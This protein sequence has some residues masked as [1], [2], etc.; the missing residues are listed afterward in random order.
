M[1]GALSDPLGHGLT[2]MQAVAV[3]GKS[4]RGSRTD[5]APAAHLLPAVTA[6]G[7]IVSQLM[8]QS[9]HP[10]APLTAHTPRYKRYHYVCDGH[11][12]NQG[13]EV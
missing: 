10:D 8:N 9:C 12:L 7:H 3:D 1:P 11:R 2:G 13:R 6:A 5:S 4:A